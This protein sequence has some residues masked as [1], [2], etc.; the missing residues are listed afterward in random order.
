M[1]Y[2]IRWRIAV[3]FVMLILISMLGLGWYLSDYMRNIYLEELEDRLTRETGLVG[4][5]LSEIFVE[6]PV[7]DNLDH[8]ARHWG[9]ILDARVTI[10]DASGEVMGES[11]E[12]RLEM[13]NHIDR[14]EV[15]QASL[16]GRGTSM[17]Y[18]RT[19][20]ANMM[21]VAMPVVVEG[22][23]AGYARLA[24]PLSQIEANLAQ[25]RRTLVSA[26]LLTAAL[27]VLLAVLIAGR[28]TRP[29]R[30]LSEA[31]GD[32][33]ASQEG[34]A[35][36][37]PSNDEV[38]QLARA[39]NLRTQQLQAQMDALRSES[40]KLEAVL[41][42]I[43]DGVLMVDAQGRVQLINPAAERIFNIKRDQTAGRSLAET[44]RNHQLVELWRSTMKTRQPQETYLDFG[45]QRLALQVNAIPLGLYLSGST[46]LFCQDQTRLRRLETTR[47]DF[48]SNI[49]HELRT[50]LASLKALSETLSESALDDPPAARR[51]LSHM[52]DELDSLIQMVS[53]LLELSRIES[54]KVLLHFRSTQPNELIDPAVERMRL[55]AERAG[56]SLE[57]EIPTGLPAVLADPPRLEQVLVNLLHNAIKF[58]P[59]GGRVHVRAS[60]GEAEVVLSVED[61]GT[62]IPASEL[63]RIFERFY[64][65]E[66]ARS[67]G[68][69]GLGLAIA[70]H[71]VEAHG[72]K[73]W[74]ESEEGRGSRFSFSLPVFSTSVSPQKG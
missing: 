13:D 17:R 49:S 45:P 11:H 24:M 72:G 50:P 62:G 33:T 15:Q 31:A 7:S 27:A 10:M 42:E 39:F 60:L 69:T 29:L 23:V 12:N 34:G 18:S 46:L 32:L 37:P 44:L 71:V 35:I 41:N 38:G 64:K 9:S 16:S 43:S 14:P 61:D 20:G 2:S 58:T 3:P 57:V 74:V 25:L 52:E 55:Q 36:I 68:G 28:T 51:F 70:R 40:L 19:V 4:D 26:S 63:E 1:F 67:V 66:R 54:G 21:Y 65:V 53:E 48:I 59:Q 8:L 22:R 73:I 56:L 47:R 30:S 5:A 6:M